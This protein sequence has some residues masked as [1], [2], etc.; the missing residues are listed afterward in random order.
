[1]RLLQKEE[2]SQVSGGTLFGLLSLFCR[3]IVICKP[4]PAPCKP[5]VEEKSCSTE[6]ETEHETPCAPK[7]RS[8]F[9]KWGRC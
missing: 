9:P 7:P 3:P 2:L 8:C 4:A 5:V 1:M 6:T